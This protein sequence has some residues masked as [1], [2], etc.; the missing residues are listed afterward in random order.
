MSLL[1]TNFN[2]SSVMFYKLHAITHLM[3][4]WFYRAWLLNNDTRFKKVLARVIYNWDISIWVTKEVCCCKNTKQ[5][6]SISFTNHMQPTAITYSVLVKQLKHIQGNKLQT[7]TQQFSSLLTPSTTCPRNK[8]SWLSPSRNRVPVWE[9]LITCYYTDGQCYKSR[10]VNAMSGNVNY[11]PQRNG[12]T[13]GSAL[14]YWPSGLTV[15]RVNASWNRLLIASCYHR[16]TWHL[17]LTWGKSIQSTSPSYL[18]NTNFNIVLRPCL[19]S[20]VFLSG[21]P[22]KTPYAL[23]LSPTRPE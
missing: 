5:T 15:T 17:S 12:A 3:I 8:F 19:S 18:L 21:F 10:V 9:R 4:I 16:S 13:S 20:G 11:M 2:T 6:I 22:T 23:L 14:V 7:S 1:G